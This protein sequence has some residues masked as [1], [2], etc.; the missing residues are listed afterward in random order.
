MYTW[1]YLSELLAVR[2]MLAQ[3]VPAGEPRDRYN[4]MRAGVADPQSQLNQ[5]LPDVFIPV[6]KVMPD[7]AEFFE[8][9][10][11]FF[12][13][14]EKLQLAAKLLDRRLGNVKFSGVDYSPFVHRAARLLHPT[15][16][17]NLVRE[18]RDWRRSRDFVVHV[19]RFVASYALRSTR[20]L[21]DELRR[22][23]C[24]HIIDAFSLE[25]EFESWDLGLP[26][27]FFDI[28]ALTAALPEFDIFVGRA[29]PEYHWTLKRKAMVVR[30]F[31]IRKGMGGHN[32]P[33]FETGLGKRV[34]Q[35]LTAQEWADFAEF[36]KVWPIWQGPSLSADE[37]RA[38]TSPSGIDLHF[39]DLQAQAVVKNAKWL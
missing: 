15:L 32:E 2:E 10:S 6:A 24:F 23:D 37:V 20:V 13:S 9:G 22:A 7:G 26:I 17:L 33:R 19:S 38:M 29:D 12:A 1:V 25:R 14:V 39:D 8:M 4:A 21:A 35:S 28:E 5:E 16:D 11:T 36:K 30:L 34:D 31:G 3:P 18:P 27:T